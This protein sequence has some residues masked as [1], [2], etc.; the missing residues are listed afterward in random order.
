VFGCVELY[1]KFSKFSSVD[2]LAT[3]HAELLQ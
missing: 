3:G 1:S 2:K